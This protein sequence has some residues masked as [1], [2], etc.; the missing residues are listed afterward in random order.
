MN[1]RNIVSF[2]I[3]YQ[4]RWFLCFNVVLYWND[5]SLYQ[6]N[7]FIPIKYTFP[8]VSLERI[9]IKIISNSNIYHFTI[10]SNIYV[11]KLNVSNELKDINIIYTTDENQ[12]KWTI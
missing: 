1:S 12:N 7:I 10:V 3:K 11:F 9:N 8:L 4:V 2:N 5:R 6:Q